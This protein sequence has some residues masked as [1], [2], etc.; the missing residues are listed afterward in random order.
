MKKS[1][2]S[3]GYSELKLVESLAGRFYGLAE[4]EKGGQV[5]ILEYRDSNYRLRSL[6]CQDGRIS[7]GS[8]DALLDSLVYSGQGLKKVPKPR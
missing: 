3:C 1:L 6:L 2:V 7:W 8:T 4:D 5:F